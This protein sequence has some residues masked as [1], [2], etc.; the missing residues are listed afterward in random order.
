MS[1]FLV[2]H[3]NYGDVNATLASAVG[4]MGSILE[5]L[6][7]FLKGTNEAVQGQ[8]APLWA[9]EQMKW[10]Q[11]YQDMHMRLSSGVKASNNVGEIFQEG[12]RRGAALF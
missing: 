7:N 4:T 5:D 12:D 10:N 8:A 2:N 9:D 11:S 1:D 3:G 6:N